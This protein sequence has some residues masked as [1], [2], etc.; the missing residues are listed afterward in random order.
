MDNNF[1][2]SSSGGNKSDNEN[3]LNPRKKQ[4]PSRNFM[5][6]T[7]SAANKASLPK[8]KILGERNNET[9]D[10]VEQHFW[11][12]PV[13]CDSNEDVER[14]FIG[15][16]PYDPVKNY[17][18]PRPKF[19]RYN[20][21]RRRKI[22]SLQE[23][24]EDRVEVSTGFDAGSIGIPELQD[25][26][27]GQESVEEAR[28]VSSESEDESG[29]ECG[30]EDDEEEMVEFVKDRCC[31]VKG[32][33]KF[34]F[35]V[36]ALVLMTQAIC[37]MNTPLPSQNVDS[38]LGF[39][40]SLNHVYGLSLSEVVFG[41]IREPVFLVERLKEGDVYDDGRQDVS[42]TS[43]EFVEDEAENKTSEV[44]ETEYLDAETVDDSNQN[45]KN[46]QLTNN[47]ILQE[48]ETEATEVVDRD[49]VEAETVDDF[50]RDDVTEED[51]SDA[52]GKDHQLTNDVEFETANDMEDGVENVLD[53][54]KTN[55]V[56]V[57]V[58]SFDLTIAILLGHVLVLTSFGAIYRSRC[59]KV[60]KEEF[61]ATE[62]STNPQSVIEEQLVTNEFV[63]PQQNDVPKEVNH[64]HIPSVELLGEFV[65]G[66]ETTTSS[67]MSPEVQTTAVSSSQT[68]KKQR[69]KNA[70]VVT[71][72][73][74]SVRRSSRLKTRSSVMSP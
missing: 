18:S 38:V 28:D 13:K 24:V 46:H 68:V 58:T 64:V 74:V 15:L 51:D 4:L 55:D 12:K 25:S 33:F 61:Q 17:L 60:E 67:N 6:P 49:Y 56:L 40:G 1:N 35:V 47:E 65:F 3:E 66:E 63:P 72:S 59:K 22:L 36:I 30:S 10:A 53:D 70:E 69:R 7:I 48:D 31:S 2:K 41:P 20:P 19:L 62:P 50:R 29:D 45:E 73:S 27:S 37:S 42:A 9:L 43:E 34:V 54:A 71:P 14:D 16:K 21:D 11:S 39:N 44:V 26:C 8:K 57:K 23:N 5:S 32:F 52:N